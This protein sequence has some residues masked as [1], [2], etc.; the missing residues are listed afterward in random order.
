MATP[1]SPETQ[2]FLL[3]VFQFNLWSAEICQLLD[4]ICLGQ[5]IFAAPCRNPD[6]FSY[7]TIF[8]RDGGP[9]SIL[10]VGFFKDISVS[11]SNVYSC[12]SFWSLLPCLITSKQ[13]LFSSRCL[14]ISDWGTTS[15][16]HHYESNSSLN[17][18]VYHINNV[19]CTT[20]GSR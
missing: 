15:G 6:T 13:K 4:S 9:W 8:V 19:Y 11:E 17:T 20:T 16:S 5:D 1:W 14:N 18:Q 3:L 7:N 12:K 2:L 10:M